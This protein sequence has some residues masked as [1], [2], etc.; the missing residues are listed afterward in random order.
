MAWAITI[1]K[2]QGLTFEKAVIDAAA[3]FAHGQVYVALSRCKT[4]EGLVLASPVTASAII[5]DDTVADFMHSGAELTD[6]ATHQ[7]GQ[8]QYDY[9]Y[10]LL[11]EL[12]NFQH[13]RRDFDLVCRLLDEYFYRLYPALLE[14]YKEK[15]Q[16]F[17]EQLTNVADKFRQQYTT[18]MQQSADYTTNTHLQERIEKAATYFHQKLDE[19]LLELL[20]STK[21]ETDNQAIRKRMDEAVFNLRESFYLK[22]EQMRHF[23]T[24]KFSAN[25][26]LQAKAV[27]TLEGSDTLFNPKAPKAGKKKGRS[28]S[29]MTDNI[30]T[31]ILYPQLYKALQEW[32]R[33]KSA[34]LTLPAYTILQQKALICMANSMPDNIELLIDIPYFGKRGGEK[35]GEEILA[36]IHHFIEEHGHELGERPTPISRTELRG[37]RRAERKAEREKNKPPKVDTKEQTYLLYQEGKSIDEIAALRMLSR[38]TIEGHLA[39]YISLGKLPLSEFVSGEKARR[40]RA[41]LPA[42]SLTEVKEK[43][44]DD[45]SYGEIRMVM[46]AFNS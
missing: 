11:D 3:S 25:D 28:A 31:D 12:F 1:H 16:L 24:H 30:P 6:E 40:I 43:L 23:C 17:K 14:Q 22:R 13:L 4:L 26:Y 2:S 38:T 10:K 9:F 33:Q 20:Q 35:F 18:L 45:I 36:V 29:S 32:R 19:L 39:H 34:E 46:A 37:Q 42:T 7:L 5:S 44:G 15:A 41:L 8:L 27:I 21:V